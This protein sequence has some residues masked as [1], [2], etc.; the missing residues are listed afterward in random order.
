M[1]LQ[2]KLNQKGLRLTQPRRVVMSILEKSDSPLS[3]QTILQRANNVGEDLGLVTVYR[4][5]DLLSDLD[6]VRRVHGPDVCQGYV[7]AS[8]GHHHHLVCQQCGKAI[9]FTGTDDLSSLLRRIQQETGFD[10]HGHLLQ[11]YGLCPQCQKRGTS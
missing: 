6:L 9:E 1:D 4:T 5:L 3:P 7:L 2:E 11:L 8:P 10:I